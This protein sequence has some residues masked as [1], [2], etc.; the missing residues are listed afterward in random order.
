MS[1][2]VSESHCQRGT[3][4]VTLEHTAHNSR[5]I[6]LD[7]RRS[8]LRPTLA[9]KNILLKILLG[10][11]QSSRNSIQHNTDKLPVRLPED[12]YLE[13]SSKIVHI[14]NFISFFNFSYALTTN[15]GRVQKYHVIW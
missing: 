12:A 10:Q 1:V 8:T 6:S 11:L 7:A 3:R 15:E 9:A 2:G 5:L 4:S 13:L 14:S